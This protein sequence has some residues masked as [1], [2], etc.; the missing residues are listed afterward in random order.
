MSGTSK[1]TQLIT[2]RLS[3]KAISEYE[4][5]VLTSPK[6]PH[7]SARVMMQEVLERYP[8]RHSTRKYREKQ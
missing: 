8:F 4:R 2:L 7:K 6:N 5:L 1:K 3:N